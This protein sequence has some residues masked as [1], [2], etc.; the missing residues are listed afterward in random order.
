M[1]TPLRVLIANDTYPPQLN[2]AAVATQRLANGLAGRGHSVAVIAPNLATH[3]A[4]MTEPGDAPGAAAVIVYRIASFSTRPVHPQ[5]RVT[6]W[7]GIAGKLERIFNEFKPDIVHIQNHFIL[8]RGCWIQARKRELPVVG[9]NHFVPDN[10]FGYIPGPLRPLVSSIMWSHY[11]RT[12]NH[13]DCV[14]SPSH[15]CLRILKSVGLTARTR[16]I[17]NGVDLQKY[18]KVISARN[19]L[20]R[21]EIRPDAPTFLTVGRL[22]QD[23]K[24]DLII[25][26]A[27]L[28][29]RHRDFQVVIVGK[30]KDEAAFQKL[31]KSMGLKDRVIFTGYVPDDEL[32]QL[33]NMAD[34]YIGAG[35]AELQGIAVM[36]A[37][38]AGLPVLAANSM[39]LPELVSD[40]DNGYLF[41][42]EPDDLSAK[43][44][45]ILDQ[46]ANWPR[47]GQRS[48]A[49][50]QSHDMPEALS[51]VE[52]L[53]AEVIASRKTAVPSTSID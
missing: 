37:M 53:Y 45:H 18:A 23:K 2:G 25:H 30:G 8:G 47:M 32:I 6:S 15:A 41:Q 24:V 51:Q 5:F 4:K 10:L 3:D 22:E 46:K 36:E 13:L 27:A 35:A 17:S 20:S 43:M 52:A 14:L 49:R 21:Y 31:A 40:G 26:A 38:A 16:V 29:G 48:L 39:A 44:L 50:I 1:L 42:L 12:Y 11:L 19:L 7:V 34:V 33:Y 28:A 9:T